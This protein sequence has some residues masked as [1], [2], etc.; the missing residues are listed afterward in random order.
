MEWI[1]PN[2]HSVKGHQVLGSLGVN[3]AAKR[4]GAG[5]PCDL[6]R[7]WPVSEDGTVM[8]DEGLE[9]VLEARREV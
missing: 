2:A 7:S 4:C 3:L 9:G 8:A 6:A 1:V 5:L